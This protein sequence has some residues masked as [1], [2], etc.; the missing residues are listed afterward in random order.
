MIY[1]LL[2]IEEWERLA[3]GRTLSNNEWLERYEKEEEL[4]KI[5]EKEELVWQRRGEENW[6][7]KGDANTS[8]FHG[9][10]NG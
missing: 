3:E 10:A 1:L 4:M 2:R 7:L 8:Y 9:I 6:L 5:Y